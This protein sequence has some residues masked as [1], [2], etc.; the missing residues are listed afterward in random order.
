MATQGASRKI[1]FR[2]I[3]GQHWSNPVQRV[4]PAY[5][6]KSATK[7]VNRFW[8]LSHIEPDFNIASPTLRLRPRRTPWQTCLGCAERDRCH[9]V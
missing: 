9:Y 8:R 7:G 1:D 2:A 3:G 4:V 5:A 6:G